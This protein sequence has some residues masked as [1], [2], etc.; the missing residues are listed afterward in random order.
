MSSHP[1]WLV[2]HPLEIRIMQ[3]LAGEHRESYRVFRVSR[4]EAALIRD[5]AEKFFD[6]R[7]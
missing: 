7:S 2:D 4:E 3:T 6:G 1:K 5:A